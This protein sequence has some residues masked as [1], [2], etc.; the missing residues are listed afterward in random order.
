MPPSLLWRNSAGIVAHR[1]RTRS[2]SPSHGR[3]HSRHSHIGPSATRQEAS[4]SLLQ[5]FIPQAW[6]TQQAGLADRSLWSLARAVA[7]PSASSRGI[8]LPQE[9]RR[10]T[11]ASQVAGTAFLPT[12][13]GVFV[14]NSQ[15]CACN[16]TVGGAR[17]PLHAKMRAGSVSSP[18][19]SRGP[20]PHSVDIGPDAEYREGLERLARSCAAL[21]VPPRCGGGE[22]ISCT[23]L[24]PVFRP[25]L[26]KRPSCD[27]CDL[28]VAR[29]R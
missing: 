15:L 24:R 12:M 14:S 19:P 28:H 10:N 21:A 4:P 27:A 29:M 6:H 26:P 11:F 17:I 9:E 22:L 16:L 7:V 8:L 23:R 20:D 2:R 18:R 13:R 5:P 1:S 3:S 25:R